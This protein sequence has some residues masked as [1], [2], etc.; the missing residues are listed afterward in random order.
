L[1]FELQIAKFQQFKLQIAKFQ[2]LIA[3]NWTTSLT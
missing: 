1:Q 2:Q 3:V